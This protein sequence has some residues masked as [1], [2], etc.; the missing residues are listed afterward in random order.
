MSF[1]SVLEAAG[2]C[3]QV[4]DRAVRASIGGLRKK[5]VQREAE[6]LA[7]ELWSEMLPRLEAALPAPGS[8]AKM[9]Q[10]YNEIHG[11][12]RDEAKAAMDIADD[13]CILTAWATVL[14]R[15]AKILRFWH[16][17]LQTLPPVSQTNQIHL[18][19]QEINIHKG[20]NVSGSKYDVK[21]I[22]STIGAQAV[23][24][25]AIANGSV[26]TGTHLS[27]EQ[28]EGQI[29]AMKKA[30]I[31]DEDS[32]GPVVI[33]ALG[34]FLRM[35]REIQVENKTLAEAQAKMKELLEEIWAKKAIA[36]ML[37]SGSKFAVE[38]A[39]SPVMVEVVKGLLSGGG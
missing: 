27:R 33:E 18:H 29:R 12:L 8:D 3:D 2:R 23:G 28:F 13:I 14:A 39:K 9:E 4:S 31:D 32:L 26:S 1:E 15:V 25:H 5:V 10:S 20:D 35:A 17:R 34:Q 16:W 36:P 30:L 37:P 38:L 7:Q 11:L 22:N 6:E 19:A 21:V 24:D